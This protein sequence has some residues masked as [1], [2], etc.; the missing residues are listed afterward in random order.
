MPSQP[1]RIGIDL[2]KYKL[3]RFDYFYSA[4]EQEKVTIPQA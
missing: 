4:Q 2:S 3:T 1:E